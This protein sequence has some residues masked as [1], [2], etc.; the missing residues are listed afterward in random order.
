MAC[1]TR[2]SSG[3][4]TSAASRCCCWEPSELLRT[5]RSRGSK[6]ESGTAAPHEPTAL[7]TTP[8]PSPSHHYL[9]ATA[10]LEGGLASSRP[11][12]R[13]I[14][15]R[16]R[17]SATRNGR[18]SPPTMIHVQRGRRNGRG[19]PRRSRSITRIIRIC[20]HNSPF[21]GIMVTRDGGCGSLASSSSLT[22]LPCPSRCTTV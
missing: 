3:G 11:W 18:R 12:V 4:T 17:A 21:H 19:E 13:S 8:L 1:C 16:E 22:R 7:T 14:R 10:I 9:R 2:R 15:N 20:C 5:F 6:F